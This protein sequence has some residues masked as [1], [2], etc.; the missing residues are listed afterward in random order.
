MKSLHHILRDFRAHAG[1]KLGCLAGLSAW[2]AL[3]YFAPQGW[4]LFPARPA[5]TLPWEEVVPF[6]PGWALVYQS[7]FVVHAL[8]IWLP[9]NAGVVRRYTLLAAAAYALSAVVFWLYPTLSPRP[10]TSDHLLYRWLVL[11]IDGPRNALPS[12]HAALGTL[13]AMQLG[14]HVPALAQSRRWRAALAA[15]W[16]ALL[17]STLATRQHRVLDLVAGVALVA[18]LAMV[19]R[20]GGS[21]SAFSPKRGDA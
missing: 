10:A 5:P 3:F 19:I 13:A 8:A 15:W 4:P 6:S 17:Y 1:L 9:G 14:Q 2:I 7:V 12:L 18:V 16:C 20:P 11:E 21:A